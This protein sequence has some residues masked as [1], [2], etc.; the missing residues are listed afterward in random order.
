MVIKN[1]YF[2]L[3]C[4]Y[5]Q[6]ISRGVLFIRQ[7]SYYI[8]GITTQWCVIIGRLPTRRTFTNRVPVLN[9]YQCSDCVV[10]EMAELTLKNDRTRLPLKF[11][12]FYELYK[13]FLKDH[14]CKWHDVSKL[15][16]VVAEILFDVDGTCSKILGKVST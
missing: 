2:K 7:E 5:L 4:K 14:G 6:I 12:S 10:K 16:S 15:L 13:R 11:S 3:S 1:I 9:K 8:G